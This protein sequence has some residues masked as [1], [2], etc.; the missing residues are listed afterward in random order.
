M[1]ML[2]RPEDL[3]LPQ[4][5]SVDV[6][7]ALRNAAGRDGEFPDADSAAQSDTCR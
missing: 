7:D 4:T 3:H 5:R 2:V 6:T 1:S